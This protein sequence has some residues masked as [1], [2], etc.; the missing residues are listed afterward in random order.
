M[1]IAWA[2]AALA[3]LTKGL[4]AVVL[5][6]LTLVG[7]SI[8]QRDWTAWRRLSIPAGLPLFLLIAVPWFVL[9]QRELPQFFDFFFIREHLA[10]YLTRI[11]DR[12]E[13]WWF[14]VPILVAGCLPWLLPA[15]RA[16][17]SGWRSSALPGEFDARRLFWTW[18]V[19]VF[20]FFSASDS[21]L[22]PY[23]LP[24]FPA[25]ALLMS[26]SDESRLRRDLQVTGLGLIVIG[27]ALV[28]LSAA[29]PSVLR[30]SVRAPYLLGLRTPTLL[31]GLVALAAGISVRRLR[32]DSLSLTLVVGAAGYICLAV[33]LWGASAV[34][35]I[36]SGAS[37]VGRLPVSLAE[38]APIFS[39]RTFDHTLPFYLRRTVTLVDERGELDFGLT[40]EPHKGID[41][42]EAFESR[43]RSSPQ[44]L[45][46]ME[47]RTFAELERRGL[48]MVVRARGLR[49]L[50]VSVQ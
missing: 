6:A 46:V 42:L 18:S 1:W 26:S 13:P 33:L 30:D 12:Y 4:I 39:V 23:I 44:A 48:P 15:T 25:L 40:L 45:A 47:P 5:P 41:S 14:F 7:Y 21:K 8:L 3:V 19:V 2:G 49:R 22:I 11:A 28:A 10:R 31:M 9:I 35:P 24:M 43:W 38:N 27:I 16:L 37:L 29:L 17:I 32:G 20:L 34:A 36:Y 50:I